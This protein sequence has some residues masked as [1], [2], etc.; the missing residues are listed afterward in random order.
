MIAMQ[1]PRVAFQGER[2]AFSEDAIHSLFPKG[3]ELL[4]CIN[5]EALFK[6]ISDERAEY[7]VAP[8]ENT[9]AG[10]VQRCYDLLLESRLHIVGEAIVAIKHC[11]IGCE[12][13]SLETIRTAASHPVALAQ[14]QRFFAAHPLIRPVPADDTAGSVRLVMETSDPLLAAIASANAAQMYGGKILARDLE[15][16]A[17]NYT[18][19]ALLAREP[20]A[21]VE[22]DKL[23]L[24][25]SIA[26]VPGALH[27]ALAP[28]AQAGIDLIKIET[29]PIAG[30]PWEYR[31]ILDVAA[32]AA[33]SRVSSALRET[34]QC[35]A[36]QEFRVLGSYK[37][38]RNLNFKMA[39]EFATK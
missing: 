38:A 33:D 37:S 5:F 9:L 10:S 24:V 19:F 13:A 29:R 11:L 39:K 12:G 25:L 4:P 30:N 20:V 2:G 31:F 18:R 23:T 1:R 26:N 32:F 6:A 17:E 15:D 21:S 36:V 14:C 27:Q 3:A 8:L 35:S 22:A 16:H 34:E 28:L 7:A